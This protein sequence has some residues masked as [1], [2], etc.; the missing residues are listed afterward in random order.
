MNDNL[1]DRIRRA[2]PGGMIY[3]MDESALVS[4][5]RDSRIRDA[6]QAITVAYPLSISI[7]PFDKP[8]YE[9]MITQSNHP[10]FDEWVWIMRNCDKLAWIDSNK[11]NPYPV[12]LLKISRVADFYYFFYNHWVPRGDTGFLDADCTREPNPK[13]Q[14]YEKTI[15]HELEIRGFAYMNSELSSEETPF[16]KEHDYDSIPDDDPRWQIEGFEPPIISSTVH[17]CLFKH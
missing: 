5:E 16:V 17:E 7:F 1:A 2:Y 14:G 13:W 11:G 3:G 15:R 10:P 6:L 4:K 12:F 8:A 9:I